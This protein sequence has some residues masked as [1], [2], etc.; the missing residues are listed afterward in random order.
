MFI[1]Q[2]VQKHS[3]RVN[4]LILNARHPCFCVAGLLISGIL[5]DNVQYKLRTA[6]TGK[7]D[8]A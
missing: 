4:Q 7:A 3:R 5:M 1:P 8:G 2:L 6:C